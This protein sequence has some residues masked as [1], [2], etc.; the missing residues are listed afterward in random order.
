[1]TG[2]S[3]LLGSRIVAQLESE[4]GNDV[5]AGFNEHPPV[6]GNAI[7]F[8]LTRV[9][10]IR[11][12]VDKIRPD[13]IVHTAAMTDVDLCETNPEL[14]NLVNAEATGKIGEIGRDLDS[15]VAFVSTDYV[16][17]G[18]T[19]S[20]RESDAPRPVNR[21]GESKALGER[22][23]QESGARFC[24]ARSSVVYGWGRPYRPN[25]AGWVIEKLASKLPVNVVV[26]QYAS[27]TLSNNLASMLLEVASRR[28]E[29][30][31]HLAG[32]TRIN[33]Y[34]FAVQIATTFGLNPDLIQH[35]MSESLSWKAKRP[36]DSSLDTSLAQKLLE[37]KPLRIEEALALL[38]AGKP[39]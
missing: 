30:T 25:F 39:K 10:E 4:G 15:Y 21:Y 2:A 28:F 32:A 24:I 23:L 14:A 13:I 37:K 7:R 1:V 34:D 11:K 36:A 31:I 38:R 29:G 26:D 12:I 20:Y 8:D 18:K 16:F 27:P 5:Y 33:R 35:V 6:A 3:G 22:L 19:G 9:N 17:D